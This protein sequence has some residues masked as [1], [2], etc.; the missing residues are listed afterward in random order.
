[1]LLKKILNMKTIKTYFSILLFLLILAGCEKILEVSPTTSLPSKGVISN[2]ATATAAVRGMYHSLQSANYYGQY[3]LIWGDLASDN[4]R[5][6]GTFTTDQE[7]DANDVLSSNST[8][9]AVWAQLYYSIS[10]ANY[11]L[12]DIPSVKGMPDS[13]KNQYRGE[14]FFVRALAYFNL[15]RSFGK[16]PLVTTPV[17]SLDQITLPGRAPVDSVYTF[18]Q[19]NLDSAIALIPAGFS[20]S[21]FNMDP[22]EL[23]GQASKM[24]AMALKARVSLFEKKWQ[25]AMDYADAVFESGQ[26][27]LEANYSDIFN[28][29]RKYSNESIFE[30]DFTRLNS[31]ALAFWLFPHTYGGRLEYEPTPEIVA[32]YDH[33]DARYIYNINEYQNS[34][35]TTTYYMVGKYNDIAS[36]SDNVIV[37]RFAEIYLIKAEAGL[38]GATDPA[39]LSPSDYIH[40]IRHRANVPDLPSVTLDDV[41][42]ERRLE[43]AFEG[44]RWYDLTRTGTA[45]AFL[46]SVTSANQYLWPVPQPEIDVNPNLKPQNNGY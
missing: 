24:A 27:V 22:A 26:F 8:L 16:V 38:H 42:N 1:M 40:E 9:E 7:I 31:N 46:P 14:A 17:R 10:C 39:G 21:N 33:S 25:N 29:N 37:L 34:G 20:K 19:S 13:T 43:F 32:A 45:E 4:L 28:Y 6:S 44:Y 2:T 36:G 3:I 35:D 23:Q 30:V 12:Q 5:H 11:I 18:I 15:T 41:Y